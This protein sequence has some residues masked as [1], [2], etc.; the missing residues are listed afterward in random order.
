MTNYVQAGEIM[1]YANGGTAISSGDTVVIGNRVGVAIT[2]IAATTGTGSV[3]LTGVY[4]MAK[5]PD[6]AFSQGDLLFYD[7]S[8]DTYTKT[9][10]GNKH[11]GVAFEA[12]ASDAT[13]CKVLLT[14]LPKQATVIAA[15]ATADGSD[16]ATTQAL[17]N[18]LKASHNS[19]IAALK[20]AGLMAN[21]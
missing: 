10:T 2:D 21:S 18:A 8:D 11:A 6:E 17:A 15:V 9:A 16:A 3:A 1:E 19:V 20:A 14:P 4:S 12:A 7:S 5:D 13:T